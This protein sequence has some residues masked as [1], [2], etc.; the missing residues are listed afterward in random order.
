MSSNIEESDCN[1]E[2]LKKTLEIH[3]TYNGLDIQV[4]VVRNRKPTRF[5]CQDVQ[6]ELAISEGSTGNVY[7]LDVFETI[8]YAVYK[9][10][11]NLKK[12][13]D[14]SQKRLIYMTCLSRALNPAIRQGG[15]NL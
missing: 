1:F 8:K 6:F 9:L 11:E 4:N 7:L 10:F 15:E 14:Q 12:A 5:S 3:E 2:D 13:Y